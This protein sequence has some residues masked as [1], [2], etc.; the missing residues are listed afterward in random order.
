[1]KIIHFIEFLFFAV[2]LYICLVWAKWIPRPSWIQEDIEPVFGVLMS[3]G[4][5]VSFFWRYINPAKYTD[6]EK[7]VVEKETEITMSGDIHIGD[8]NSTDTNTY[9]IKNKVGERSKISGKNFH[10]GDDNR[11]NPTK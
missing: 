5:L 9:K 6:T 4:A 1:M 11:P 3:T 8:K 2:G 10:L 7:N